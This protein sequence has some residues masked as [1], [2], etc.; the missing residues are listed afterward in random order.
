MNPKTPFLFVAS[1]LF[2]LCC[3]TAP[4]P[5][6]ATATASTE[7]APEPAAPKWCVVTNP[8]ATTV[9][10]ACCDSSGR[11][12]GTYTCSNIDFTPK[13]VDCRYGDANDSVYCVAKCAGAK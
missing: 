4:M 5:E 12:D 2:A 9:M 3:G 7:A 10:T 1:M 11:K 13:F 8:S 6:E